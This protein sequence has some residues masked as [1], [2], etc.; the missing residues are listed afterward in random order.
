MCIG[1]L[2]SSLCPCCRTDDYKTLLNKQLR[3]VVISLRVKCPNK[4][5]TWQGELGDRIKHIIERCEFGEG[6]C[7]YGCG[8]K[9]MK[10][11]LIIHEKDAC[12]KI[13][14]TVAIQRFQEL[15]KVTV[16]EMKSV[17]H[18]EIEALQT[19]LIDQKKIISSCIDKQDEYEQEIADLRTRLKQQEEKGDLIKT[20]LTKTD[21]TKTDLIKTD[22]SNGKLPSTNCLRNVQNSMRYELFLLL[23]LLLLVYY[24]H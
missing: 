2:S 18:I 24:Y 3:G 10:K 19:E 13:P 16:E 11:D 17:H 4:Q 5:C 9:L 7:Q 20:D 15:M 6:V 23:L 1:R 8:I 14:V 12:P 21:L 22:L